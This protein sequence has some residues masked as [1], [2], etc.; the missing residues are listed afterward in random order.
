MPVY[1]IFTNEQL[2]QMVTEA[3]ATKA[4]L[5]KIAGVGDARVEKYGPRFLELLGETAGTSR[6][7]RAGRLFDADPRPRQPAAGRAP[8]AARQADRGDARALDRPIS[9]PT[10]IGWPAQL[11]GGTFPVG[12]YHQFVIHDPKE[13]IITAPCFAE[14]VLHHAMMNVCEP[15]FER[16]LIADTL[17]LPQGQGPHRGAATGRGSSPGGIRYFLKLDIRKYFD[18]VPHDRL[19][20]CGWQA[21]QGPAPAGPCWQRSCA[22]SADASGA[23][24]RSAA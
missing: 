7:K 1:T 6:M 22:A 10:W 21:V 23:V 2:A 8:G 5:E 11:A 15:H 19:L 3:G 9:T 14:R 17:R 24:C 20:D 16:W 18:S 12:R 13:R 4:A